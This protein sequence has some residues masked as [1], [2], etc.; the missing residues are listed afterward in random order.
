MYNLDIANLMTCSTTPP[1][2]LY[3]LTNITPGAI[4]NAITWTNQRYA[5]SVPKP[6]Y[7][8]EVIN[9]VAKVSS[10]QIPGPASGVKGDPYTT[11]MELHYKVSAVTAAILTGKSD[12]GTQY[13]DAVDFKNGYIK[14]IL[15]AGLLRENDEYA[16]DSTSA[17]SFLATV[18]LFGEKRYVWLPMLNGNGEQIRDFF[19]DNCQK[20]NVRDAILQNMRTAA[21]ALKDIEI[22]EQHFA[23][24]KEHDQGVVLHALAGLSEAV[25]SLKDADQLP[26]TPDTPARPDIR[27]VQEELGRAKHL[28]L[29]LESN[30]PEAMSQRQT[31]GKENRVRP[32]LNTY[33]Y[34]AFSAAGSADCHGAQV[35]VN[36]P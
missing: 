28:I 32:L 26:K 33:R 13:N 11:T 29:A 17:A 15:S 31:D 35:G 16:C 30:A 25:E 1:S 24:P 18:K 36:G 34:V 2:T 8:K 27:V 22:I 7:Y 21:A 10:N 12:K 20:D 9:N 6:C 5:F 14:F 4:Q 23:D 19:L 3:P